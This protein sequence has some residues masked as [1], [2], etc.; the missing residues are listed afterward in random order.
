M[1]SPADG[2]RYLARTDKDERNNLLFTKG[3]VCTG[4][5]ISVMFLIFVIASD[6]Y[7][8]PQRPAMFPNIKTDV[9]I[10]LVKVRQSLSF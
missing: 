5:A 8:L 10:I 9:V 2:K 7:K 4:C 3:C 1:M 6:V